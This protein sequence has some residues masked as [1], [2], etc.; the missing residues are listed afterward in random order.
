MRKLR[1]LT[2]TSP[3]ERKTNEQIREKEGV[4]SIVNKCREGR[5]RWLGLIERMDTE[6]GV[7]R[8]RKVAV[9]KRIRGRP[10]KRWE[11]TVREDMRKLG[12]ELETAQDRKEWRRRTT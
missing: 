6:S 7:V 12:I 10:K 4:V 8:A 9:G 2:G 3:R 1:W 5:L 11:K